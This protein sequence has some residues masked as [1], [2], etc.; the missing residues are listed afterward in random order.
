MRKIFIIL[1]AAISLNAFSQLPNNFKIE[2]DVLSI[3]TDF[4]LIGINGIIEGSVFSLTTD[5]TLTVNGSVNGK[6]K[7][8]LFSFGTTITIYDGKNNKIG[9]IKEELFQSF[10]M[11]SKYTIYDKS[12]V[13]IASS[14]KHELMVTK[15]N[16]I[17]NKG[18]VIC[19]ISRPAMNFGGDTWNISFSNSNKYDKML[20]IFIPCYKT[21]RD[22]EK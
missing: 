15:F 2:E 12:D 20:F 8:S 11:Y 10:G 18:N 19:E 16:I 3:G 21:Y 9:Y 17:D 4:S 5:F 6:S 14:T 1:F 22:N 13:K 7:Q